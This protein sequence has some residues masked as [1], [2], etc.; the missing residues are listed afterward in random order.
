MEVGEDRLSRIYITP[1]AYLYHHCH[2]IH[3]RA[4]IFLVVLSALTLHFISVSNTASTQT[5]RLLNFIS[6]TKCD[7]SVLL[8]R[9]KSEKRK[10]SIP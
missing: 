7:C 4:D 6:K 8:I 5:D 10:P 1:V 3:A 2:P 9:L